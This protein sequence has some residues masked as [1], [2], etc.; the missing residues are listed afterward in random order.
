MSNLYYETLERESQKESNE[1][2]KICDWLNEAIPLV[3][4]GTANRLEKI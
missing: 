4:N 2:T 1:F 3:K